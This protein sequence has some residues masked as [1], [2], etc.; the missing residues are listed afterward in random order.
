MCTF[1]ISLWFF[2]IQLKN[3]HFFCIVVLFEYQTNNTVVSAGNLL[4]Y[5][6]SKELCLVYGDWKFCPYCVLKY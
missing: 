4:G 6:F 2:V 3:F 5:D 1:V